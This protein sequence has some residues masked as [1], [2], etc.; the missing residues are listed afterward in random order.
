[1]IGL[2]PNFTGNKTSRKPQ[3]ALGVVVKDEL[4]ARYD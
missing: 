3:N 2:H 1:M 4:K